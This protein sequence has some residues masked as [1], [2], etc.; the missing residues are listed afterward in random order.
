MWKT[1]KPAEPKSTAA[2]WEWATNPPTGYRRAKLSDNAVPLVCLKCGAAVTDSA[3]EL[4]DDW[5]AH[6]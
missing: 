5:H 3:V 2:D 1:A 6:G 4:H